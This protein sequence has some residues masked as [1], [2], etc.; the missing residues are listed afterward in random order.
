MGRS[1]RRGALTRHGSVAKL[2]FRLAVNDKKPLPAGGKERNAALSRRSHPT[3][4]CRKTHVP[5]C[6]ER[7]KKPLS[8]REKT[9]ITCP[10]AS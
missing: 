2:P 1:R 6:G 8:A 9:R 10:A 3:W 5:H 4:E 7:R